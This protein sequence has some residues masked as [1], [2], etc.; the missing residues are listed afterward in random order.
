MNDLTVNA[1]RSKGVIPRYMELATGI[2]LVLIESAFRDSQDGEAGMVVPDPEG[3]EAAAAVA[4]ITEP[5]KLRG[6]EIR[7]LRRA[8]RMKAIDLAKF[9]DVRPETFSR[10]E[11][12]R[13]PISTNA[14]RILRLRVLHTLR[15]RARFVRANDDEIL[16]M[17]F[18]SVRD[19]LEPIA[20]MFQRLPAATENG[21]CEEA[22]IYRGIEQKEGQ[23]AREAQVVAALRA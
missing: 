2:P 7:F 1:T 15:A 14:E 11:H 8:L 13:E 12:E 18:I 20:L 5:L 9:L 4:R 6:S 19:C 10:W 16:E 22:W 3:L 17:K 23:Q 21:D